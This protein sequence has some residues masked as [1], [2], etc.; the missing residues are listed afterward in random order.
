MDGKI[1]RADQNPGHQRQFR[2]ESL[3]DLGKGRNHEQVDDHDRHRH[4]DHDEGGITHRRLDLVARAFLEFQVVEKPQEDFLQHP[5]ASP[6]RSM[7][8]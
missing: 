4:R 8:T 7:L 6:T 1:R 3:V 5:V 2:I